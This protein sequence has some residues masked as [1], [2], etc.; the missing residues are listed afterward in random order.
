M[1]KTFLFI[2]QGSRLSLGSPQAR[3]RHRFLASSPCAFL[4][5]HP[6]TEM[7]VNSDYKDVPY[8]QEKIKA[9]KHHIISNRATIAAWGASEPF[10]PLLPYVKEQLK[11]E[12]RDWV[13]VVGDQPCQ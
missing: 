5:P 13:E 10:Y 9:L 12:L 4:S 3:N 7:E 8:L 6:G 2:T 11:R 1:T